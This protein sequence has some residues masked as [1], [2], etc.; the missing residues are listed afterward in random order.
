MKELRDAIISLGV[1][2]DGGIVKVD[3][4]LNH[5]LDTALLVKMGQAFQEAFA[6]EKVDLILTVESSGI[7]IALTTAMAFGNLPVVFA[8]KGR[9]SNLA[10]EMYQSKA[11]SY[12]RGEECTISVTKTY[13]PTGSRVLVIDDFLANG[14]ASQ[15]LLDIAEQAGVHVVGVG[16]C[17]EKSFQPG[18][19]KL[20]G[21]GYPV[22]A[23][24]TVTGIK[25]GKPVLAEE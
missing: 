24:A 8:K 2:K 20:R 25:D 4:F 11:Y 3:M 10:G 18:G 5:Q 17:V 9:P 19:A 23:L 21:R 1:G 12:T 6:K 7:A 16:V 14:E 22:V 13:L 15:G